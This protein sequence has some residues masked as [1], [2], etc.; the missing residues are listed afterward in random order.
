MLLQRL[1]RFFLFLRG[2]MGVD[3]HGHGWI[4]MAEK[5]LGSFHIHAGIVEH[6]GV[7][8]AK[9]VSSEPVHSDNLGMA[10]AGIPSPCLDVQVVHVGVPGGGPGRIGHHAAV[11]RRTYIQGSV[12]P[13]LPEDGNELGWE[14]HDPIA[15]RR[16]GSLD[17]R[18]ILSEG[19]R[20]GDGGGHG[21]RA[22]EEK[23]VNR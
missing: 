2:K 12:S 21:F 16:L 8:M 19:G 1:N 14:R 5:V 9:L 3:V 23:S 11:R 18:L 4:S 7:G 15:C 20:L 13:Y 22:C 6:S 17:L 10:A